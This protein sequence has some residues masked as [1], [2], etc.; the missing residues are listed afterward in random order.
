MCFFV[1]SIKNAK[2]TLSENTA[3]DFYF[4]QNKITKV[5]DSFE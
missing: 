5:V 2:N 3:N 4:K 1:S